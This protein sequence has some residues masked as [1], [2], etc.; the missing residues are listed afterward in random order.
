MMAVTPSLHIQSGSNTGFSPIIFYF[1]PASLSRSPFIF[2]RDE[3]SFADIV[4]ELSRLPVAGMKG[5]NLKT[6]VGEADFVS[7]IKKVR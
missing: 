3:A 1:A 2:V 6:E 4:S 7:E 5:L